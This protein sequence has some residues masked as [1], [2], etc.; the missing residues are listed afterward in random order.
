MRQLFDSS[1]EQ[2]Q[3]IDKRKSRHFRGWEGL[4]AEYTNGRPDQREQV[5]LWTEHA[6]LDAAVEPKYLRLLGPNQ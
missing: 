5:D 3:L 2:K 1:L 4:G 6:A